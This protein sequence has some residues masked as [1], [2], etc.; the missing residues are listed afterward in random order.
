MY[1]EI[2]YHV[3]HDVKGKIHKKLRFNKGGFLVITLEPS[4]NKKIYLVR[5]Y[6]NS[7]LVRTMRYN[8]EGFTKFILENAIT[9]IYVEKVMNNYE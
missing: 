1:R 5:F 3:A 9:S 8:K 2:D 4:V 7:L 6:Y